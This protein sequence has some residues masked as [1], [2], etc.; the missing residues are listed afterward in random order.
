MIARVDRWDSLIQYH[1]QETSQQYALDAIAH[2]L[3]VKAIIAQE[4]QFDPRA[5]NDSSGATG[6]M[7]VMPGA[8]GTIEQLLD[9]DFNLHVGCAVLCDKWVIFKAEEG[10]E[11]W[12]FALGAYNGGQGDIIRAQ[13]LLTS[14]ARPTNVWNEIASVL[15]QMKS[16]ENATQNIQYVRVVF[17]HFLALRAAYG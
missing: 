4:S 15:P 6:L 5:R 9:P 8:L 14:R 2:W 10:A 13:V 7:Q 16:A 17:T 12:K 1:W 11:R 3:L